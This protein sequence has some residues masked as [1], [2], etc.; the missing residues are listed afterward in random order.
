[1]KLDDTA[2]INEFADEAFCG[3]EAPAACLSMTGQ[4]SQKMNK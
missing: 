2:G 1:M 3:Q 4:D